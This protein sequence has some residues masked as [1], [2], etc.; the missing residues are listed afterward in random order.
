V[1]VKELVEDAVL[2]IPRNEIHPDPDQPRVK[3]D[4]ELQASIDS[5]GIIQAIT[6]R[7]HPS[8]ENEWMIVDGE[9]RYLGGAHLKTLPCRIRL[10]LEEPV[11]RLITQ[12]AANSGKP[13]TPIEQAQA[14]KK[15]LDSDKKLSQAELSR[16]LGIARSTI[17]DRIRLIEI[18]SVWMKLMES[19]RLQ[20]SHAPLIHQYR[21]VPDEYQVKAA[22]K[23]SAGEG[24]QIAKYEKGDVISIASM[25]DILR[26]AFKDYVVKLDEVRSY[27]GPV[28][29]IEHE[30]YSFGPG[31]KKTRKVK[32]AADI[33]LWRP[34]KRE[35]EKRA[36]KARESSPRGS[37]A[38]RF[39]SNF[40]KAIKSLK[41]AGLDL[42]KRK[43][44]AHRSKP[45]DGETV[46]FTSSGWEKGL[47]PKVLLEKLDPSTLVLVDGQYGGDEILT[48][49]ETA[50]RA[51]QEAYAKHAA[52]VSK[53]ELQ[54][55]RAKLTPGILEKYAVR[56]AGVPHLLL[57]VEP[58]RGTPKVIALAIGLSIAGA[59]DEDFDEDDAILANDS[60]SDAEK[61]LSAI[62]AVRALDL[63]VP[64]EW[65][66]S[67]KIN[68]GLDVAFKIDK[69]KIKAAAATAEKEK[70]VPI[71][72]ATEIDDNAWEPTEQE[73]KREFE[74]A[75]A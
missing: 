46:I 8:I 9:R 49:D 61:L 44:G 7:P 6:V 3:V 63:K 66:I 75:N 47:H 51:A 24:W 12:L 54:T 36:K 26:D 18:H 42:P 10:D 14:F 45:V 27:K 40:T 34:I 4:A 74:D 64:D 65:A 13:L 60:L 23:I 2:Y 5:E 11:V 16:R 69:A 32:Y 41:A 31:P 58:T 56:G 22:A 62:A 17:G 70:Q 68:A 29:E 59:V 39:E 21:A 53:K 48:T 19:G 38:P 71:A 28:L 35:A 43:V 30:I 73:E 1:T 57:A 37:S 15:A 20:V 52:D 67:R 25:R 50:V 33:T 55:L 72:A